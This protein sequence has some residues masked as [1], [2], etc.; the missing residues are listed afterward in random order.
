MNIGGFC[1]LHAISSSNVD[2]GNHLGSELEF[3]CSCNVFNCLVWIIALF[4][5]C[6]SVCVRESVRTLQFPLRRAR[7]A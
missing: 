4:G 7:L 1:T 3:T 5:P 6:H 2:F